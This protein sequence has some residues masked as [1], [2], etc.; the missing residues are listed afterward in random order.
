MKFVGAY[1]LLSGNGTF[2]LCLRLESG[3]SL[4]SHWERRLIICNRGSIKGSG[5]AREVGSAD[6]PR[7]LEL[8][9]D[10][11]G[12]SYDSGDSV[13]VVESGK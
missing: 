9:S 12:F 4:A 6:K 11:R 5:W 13:N 8:A 2:I 1:G 7:A 10:G 3:E